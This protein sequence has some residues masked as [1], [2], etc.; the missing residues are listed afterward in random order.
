M[1]RESTKDFSF[2]LL[3]C[4]IPHQIPMFRTSFSSAFNRDLILLHAA[5]TDGLAV[6]S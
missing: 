4:D 6:V 2:R 5:A 1:L 3:Y